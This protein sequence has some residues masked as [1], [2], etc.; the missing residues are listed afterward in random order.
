MCG[1]LDTRHRDI[2]HAPTVAPAARNRGSCQS[3]DAGG[4]GGLLSAQA[5]AR[6]EADV[7]PAEVGAQPH[8]WRRWIGPCFSCSPRS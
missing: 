1:Y 8:R 3:Q 2:G 4:A 7:C 6:A 5:A